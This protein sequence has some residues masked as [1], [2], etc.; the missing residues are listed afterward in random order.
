LR[1]LGVTPSDNALEGFSAS[2]I[3]DSV[4]RTFALPDITTVRAR[5]QPECSVYA[6]ASDGVN[7]TVTF[8]VV[9]AL[10]TDDAGL[11][12]S[13]IDWKSDVTPAADVIEGYTNQVRDYLDAMGI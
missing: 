8:G 13:V 6:S 1:S 4:C 12:V 11:P 9:D 7:E 3:A 2:E 10:V 5:I